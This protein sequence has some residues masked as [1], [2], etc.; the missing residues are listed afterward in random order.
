M[1]LRPEVRET[2]RF[3][4]ALDA[5]YTRATTRLNRALACRAAV[6]AEQDRKVATAR[7]DVERAVAEMAYQVSIELTVQL[8]GL[9]PG[10]VRRMARTYPPATVSERNGQKAASDGSKQ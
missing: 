8:L 4:A 9:E 1:P 10:D 7:A 6:L 5:T 3:L 2:Q